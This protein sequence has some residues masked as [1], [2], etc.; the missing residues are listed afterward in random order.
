MTFCSLNLLFLASLFDPAHV[1]FSSWFLTA[2]IMKIHHQ[3]HH[4]TYVTNLNVLEEKNH[5]LLEK[6]NVLEEIALQPALKFNGGGRP[7]LFVLYC[8]F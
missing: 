5:E 7:F 4:N 6:S 2:D 3:K 8:T 1:L